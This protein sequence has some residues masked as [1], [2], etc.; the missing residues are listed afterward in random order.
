LNI[1]RPSPLAVRHIVCPAR[2]VYPRVPQISHPG[3]DMASSKDS[4][5]APAG[6]DIAAYID[7]PSERRA[8]A[9]AHAA[10]LA[11]TADRVAREIPF[12]A[13]VDDF[14][15]VLTQGTKP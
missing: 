13:D 9:K 11:R 7:M 1:K 12:G 15:R 5:T 10:M 2:G 14:R 8:A 3:T 4:E 6:D